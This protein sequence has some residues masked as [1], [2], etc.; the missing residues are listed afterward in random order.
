MKKVLFVFFTLLVLIGCPNPGPDTAAI[1]SDNEIL[2]FGFRAD[3]NPSLS[4]DVEG[5]ISGRRIYLIV[6]FGT[7][8]STLVANFEL[9]GGSAYVDGTAVRSGSTILDYSRLVVMRVTASDGTNA[10]YRI[11]VTE[12]ADQSR[13]DLLSFEFSATNNTEL[14]KTIAQR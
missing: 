11:L 13:K 8:L 7:D 9:S 14:Q 6:P 4:I 5:T 10:D 2:S 12:E 1:N 3:E